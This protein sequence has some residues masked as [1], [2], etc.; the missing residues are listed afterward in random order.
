MIDRPFTDISTY[1]TQK[2]RKIIHAFSEIIFVFSCTLYF[3]RTSFFALIVVHFDVCVYIQHTT[4]ISM[5]P[6][7]F[8]TQPQQP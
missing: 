1:A 2:R 4:Q 8:E 7:G 5:P 6:A 3:N